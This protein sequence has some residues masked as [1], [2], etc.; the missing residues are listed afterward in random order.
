MK[1]VPAPLPRYRYFA[2]YKRRL[3]A[4]IGLQAAEVVG[5][6]FRWYVGTLAFMVLGIVAALGAHPGSSA[7]GLVAVIG[8]LMLGACCIGRG[9][10]LSVR[11]GRLAS[12]YLTKE[13]GH[14]VDIPVAKVTLAW[15]RER[16]ADE[17]PQHGSPPT[18]VD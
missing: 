11:G 14:R 13:L 15:W 7:A 16:I 10:I 2:R 17:R 9:L 18:A 12:D 4:L 5:A 1:L 6:V 8:S 3:V